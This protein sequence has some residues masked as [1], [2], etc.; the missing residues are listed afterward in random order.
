MKHSNL[1]QLSYVGEDGEEPLT[2]DNPDIVHIAKD[3]GFIPVQTHNYNENGIYLVSVRC[4]ADMW[5]GKLENANPRHV[6]YELTG[7]VIEA[8]RKRKLIIVIDNQSEG[9][10]LVYKNIDG[11]KE[12]HQAMK[13][14]RLPKHSVVLVD[15]NAHF[16]TEYTRWCLE[17]RCKP[18][19]AHVYFITGFYYFVKGVPNNPLVLDAINTSTSK[20][21]NSLNRTAR[22][23]RVEHLYY[24]ILKKLVDKGL[25]S[26][27]YSNNLNSSWI[28]ESRILEQ[29]Y[30]VFSKILKEN[31]PLIADKNVIVDNPD[32]NEE[33]VFNHSI[34]KNS[35]LSFVTETAFHQPGMFITEKSFKPIVAGHPFIILGQ[36]HILKELNKMGYRTDFPGID[37]SYDEILD[38]VDRFYAAHNSLIKWIN[39]SRKDKE[40]YLRESLKILKH[41]QTVFKSHDYTYESYKRLLK[42]TREIFS[43]SYRNNEKNKLC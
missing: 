22:Q 9:F 26:G 25:V 38:P 42:T 17:N 19:I 2:F 18:L 37:Q 23:H 30:S 29:Q 28:P 33:T 6:L 20:D 27:H 8:A 16:L 21:Y 12:M 41:N 1:H 15:S 7:D 35:L 34:Y 32:Y 40:M 3:V 5:S 39:T 36:H 14:L 11:Y 43:G 24:L 31:L 13:N 4:Y 10:P